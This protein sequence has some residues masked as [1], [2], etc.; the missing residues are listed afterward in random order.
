MSHPIPCRQRGALELRLV[1]GVGEQQAVPNQNR[2]KQKV[3]LGVHPALGTLGAG[4]PEGGR[5]LERRL[6]G[7]SVR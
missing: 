2:A 7:D 6:T 5:Y 3:S 1:P 4:N